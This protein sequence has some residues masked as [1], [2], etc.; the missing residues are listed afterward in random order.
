MRHLFRKPKILISAGLLLAGLL[1]FWFC[2]PKPLFNRPTSYV[3]DDDQGQLLGAAIAADGQW[4]FPYDETVPEKF[5]QCIIAFEDKRFEYHWGIDPLAFGRAV[6][7]NLKKGHVT[8]GGSTLTMQVI[9]MATRHNRNIWNKLL[10]MIMALRL[11][12]TYS[13]SEILALYTSNAP[14]GGNVIGLNAASW[15]YYGRSPAQLSWGEMAAMAVLPNSPAL[16]HPGKNRTTLLRKRNQLL[17][18]LC[19][20]KVID[21]STANLAKLEPMPDKP[22]PL[23]QLAPHLLERFKAE[24]QGKGQTGLR[25]KTTLKAELQQQVSD[26]LERHHRI[27]RANQVNNI[28]AVVLD[29]ETGAALAYAGNIYHPEQAQLE[30]HV[31]VVNAPRSPG[32]TLKPLLYASMLHDGFILPNSLIADIPTQIAGYHPENYDLG[33]DGAVPA[34]RALARSLNVPAVKMLQKYK[35]ERFYDVLKKAGITTL[36]QP[37]DHYGLSL[38]LGGSENTLWELTGAYASMARVLNHYNQRNGFYTASDYHAPVYQPVANQKYQSEKFGLL[39]AGSI[40]YTLQAMQEV[41]RPGEEMLWQ[42]FGSTQRVAWKTGTSFGFRDGWAIG[43]TPKYVVGVWVGNTTGEGRPD[44]TGINTA[45]PA[46]FEIFRLLPVTREWFAEPA[47]ALV[48]IKVC[49]ESGYRAGEYCEHPDDT[50]VP[51]PGLKSPVCP[52]HQLVHLDA[53]RRWQV[54]ADCESADR[55]VNQKWFVL[56]P[57]IEYYYKTKNYQYHTLPPFRS[58]CAVA[59]KAQPME[60][61]YPKSEAKVY[62][63]IEADGTR[64][65]MICNAAHSQPGA[66]IF[67][68]LDDQYVGET[69]DFHQLAISPPAGEHVLTLVDSEGN[70][71]RVRFRVLNKENK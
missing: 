38:I 65:K 17:D 9:R 71:V 52:Y 37:A 15:R 29:V 51:A 60:L 56:P 22:L 61:I 1:A 2:L 33:Y 35:Y 8:S 67:W 34:S 69:H 27:L 70:T 57:S 10:E 54:S 31:D 20:Q 45:A 68:H 14:F 6:R 16:V 23:P 11:E 25:L 36:N 66:K 53:S 40:Y 21:Q 39:D 62:I 44:L 64:G 63:P 26:I 5:K 12:L 24:H 7:Q 50:W 46:M 49:R 42:Q 47:K 32:S 48:K 58:D 41:M 3:I 18:K 59:D 13:K 30:S 43:I 19:L 28:A 4:R 55:I